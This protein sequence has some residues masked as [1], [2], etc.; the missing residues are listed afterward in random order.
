MKFAVFAC[1]FLGVSAFGE[2]IDFGTSDLNHASVEVIDVN[3]SGFTADLILPGFD[4]SASVQN[5]ILFH[6]L[7]VASMNPYAEYEGA[8][9][10]PKASFMAA[11]PLN[12]DVTITLEPLVEPVEFQG[13]NPSPMQPIPLDSDY[14]PIPFTYDP[15]AY[16]HGTY[17]S[18][19]AAF[20]KTGTIR[21]VTMG[22]FTVLPFQWNAETGVLTVTPAVRVH[23][24]FS[25]ALSFDQRLN[26]RFFSNAFRTLVNAQLIGEPQ[27]VVSSSSP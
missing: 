15:Q 25:E 13:V 8:P 2:W 12:G 11:V 20:E 9:T 19:A 27:R 16:A 18:T 24:E 14:Q 3:E 26:S 6:S 17:P 10:L 1:I 21:G 5:G 4:N 23:V 7:G 22:K